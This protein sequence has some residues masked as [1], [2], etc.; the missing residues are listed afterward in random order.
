VRPH[1]R[2]AGRQTVGVQDINPELDSTDENSPPPEHELAGHAA[3]A[4]WLDTLCAAYA[5][6]VR[7]SAPRR[8]VA[9]RGR[10]PV[11][12]YLARELAAMAEP[13]VNVL[14]HTSGATQ[15]F[16]EFTV[17]FHLVA[18]GIEGVNLPLGA[19]I[20]LERLRVLTHDGDG[21]IAVETCI[22]TW[23]W[24]SDRQDPAG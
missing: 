13:R 22:E 3:V 9:R 15:S 16:H 1:A 7:W 5:E 6:D 20:E 21:R 4:G 14:R 12:A 19:E 23:T 8:G 10:S 18:P 11:V 2:P 17:R 24:L